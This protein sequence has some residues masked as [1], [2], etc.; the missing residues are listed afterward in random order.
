MDRYGSQETRYRFV[1]NQQGNHHED[2]GA[3][4]AGEV[5]ELTSAETK[6]VI[7]R[8]FSGIGVGKRRQQQGAGVRRHMKAIRHQRDR[9]IQQTAD[10][11]DHHHDAAQDDHEPG[12]AL[13]SLMAFAKEHMVVRRS[14]ARLLVV[15]EQL[16]SFYGGSRRGRSER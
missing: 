12:P 2:D 15:H 11:L 16:F 5:A 6:A 14:A 3:G 1:T 9:S 10:D 13:V 8:I 7:M 4:E